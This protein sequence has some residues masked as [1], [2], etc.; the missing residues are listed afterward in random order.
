VDVEIILGQVLRDGSPPP[1]SAGVKVYP[2]LAPQG[3][4][5]P[6]ASYQRVSAIPEVSLDGESGIDLVRVQI[7]AWGATMSEAKVLAGEI[8]QAMK[9]SSLDGTLKS[10]PDTSF[11]DYEPELRQFRSSADYLCW[12]K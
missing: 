8:R 10:R 2:L 1:T 6:Y 11:D 12:Q 4:V 5:P 7:D 9:T 3:T